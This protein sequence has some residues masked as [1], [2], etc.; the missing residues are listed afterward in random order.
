MRKLAAMGTLALALSLGAIPVVNA[1]GVSARVPVP[2]VRVVAASHIWQASRT[3]GTLHGTSRISLTSTYNSGKVSVSL[4]GVKK[5]DAIHMWVSARKGTGKAVTI[6]ST[7]TTVATSTSK[8]SFSLMLNRARTHR[9]RD[10]LKAGE[11][12]TFHSTDG[13]RTLTTLYVKR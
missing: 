4:T 7:R 5:G 8:L 10:L 6:I 12:L 3:T 11:A 2:S 13:S 1:A 9:I